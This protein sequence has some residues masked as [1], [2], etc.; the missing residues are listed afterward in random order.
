MLRLLW[1]IGLEVKSGRLGS[2][3][4]CVIA[5]GNVYYGKGRSSVFAIAR[6]KV[7]QDLYMCW[8]V[9]ESEVGGASSHDRRTEGL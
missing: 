7:T 5:R 6:G 9:T 3:C 1:L 4:S 2:W 8:K